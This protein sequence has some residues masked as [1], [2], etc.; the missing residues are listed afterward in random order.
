MSRT[1]HRA[2]ARRSCSRILYGVP[3]LLLS[4]LLRVAR[5]RPAAGRRV[6]DE[7]RLPGRDR[8]AQA[9]RQGVYIAV[10]YQRHVERDRVAHLG[11]GDPAPA[12]R[13][14]RRDPVLVRPQRRATSSASRGSWSPLALTHNLD[15]WVRHHTERY[16]VRLRQHPRQHQQARHPEQLRHAASGSTR[17]AET[18]ARHPQVGDHRRLRGDRADDPDRGAPAPRQAP[19]RTSWSATRAIRSTCTSRPTAAAGAT[20]L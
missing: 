1:Y 14:R 11:L 19:G 6:D 3:L 8:A 4:I 10:Q 12:D 2:A 16:P 15:K 20:A 18:V 17:R 9:G 13:A 7:P 5:A